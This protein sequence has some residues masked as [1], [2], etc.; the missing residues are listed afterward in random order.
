[1]R[2]ILLDS[3]RNP[4]DVAA[5]LGLEEEDGA[6]AKV[7]VDEVFGFVGNEGSEISAYNAVPCWAFTLIEL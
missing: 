1:M 3:V 7:E 5:L 4:V 2:R 6:M